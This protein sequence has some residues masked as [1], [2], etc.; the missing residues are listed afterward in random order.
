MTALLAALWQ[1]LA[2]TGI[3]AL[4]L[5]S[6]PRLGA[7]TRYTAWWLALATVLALPIYHLTSEPVAME[8]SVALS[9]SARQDAP[10]AS[11]LF[12][13]ARQALPLVLP[14]P[15]DGLVVGTLGAWGL[16]LILGGLRLAGSLTALHQLKRQSVTL[17]EVLQQRLPMWRAARSSGRCPELRQSSRV[18]SACAAGLHGRPVIVVPTGLLKALDPVDLDHIVMHEHAH[19]E[20]YDDWTRL[21]QSI[22]AIVA[23]L[24]PAVAVITRRLEFEREAACDDRVVARSG[25]ALRYARCLAAAADLANTRA[26]PLVHRLTPS[27]TSGDALVARIARLVNRDRAHSRPPAS[28]GAAVCALAASVATAIAVD[29]A[30]LVVMQRPDASLPAVSSLRSE[31][32]QPWSLPREP[33]S[34]WAAP[35]QVSRRPLGRTTSHP[36][37]V[38][39]QQGERREVATVTQEAAAPVPGHATS[40]KPQ[41]EAH[42][43]PAPVPRALDEPALLESRAW[44]VVTTAPS[45]SAAQ[46]WNGIG[47]RASAVGRSIAQAGIVT[48]TE[49]RSAGR[50]VA[51]LVTR[52]GKGLSRRL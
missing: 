20:R 5:R 17:D 26:R 24:H 29:R 1:G 21:G 49:V 46:A 2:V 25:A 3:T 47:D 4:A 39:P 41:I 42:A 16:W 10:A 48:G 23:G 13:Q 38:A 15:P 7:A 37:R 19:L 51:G 43:A 32:P 50:A 34:V 45:P 44:S 9:A 12:K 31:E 30:P 52:A 14:V 8:R 11:P 22:V 40:S 36:A 35:S 6:L 27:A 28:L 18:S 33:G